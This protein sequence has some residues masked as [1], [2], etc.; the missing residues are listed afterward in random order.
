MFSPE[1][2]I[3]ELRRG[4]LISFGIGMFAGA[5]GLFLLFLLNVFGGIK[6]DL[7]LRIFLVV[8]L[9]VLFSFVHFS[10]FFK[11][12]D[13]KEK[14]DN[15][16]FVQILIDC[17]ALFFAV[18]YGGML[19]WILPIFMIVLL[20]YSYSLL[21]RK[22][23]III[24]I[25]L[26]FGIIFL[27][28]FEYFKILPSYQPFNVGVSQDFKYF[29]TTLLIFSGT[30]IAISVT[31]DFFAGRLQ[32]QNEL[33]KERYQENEELKQSLEIRV[34]AR[35][36]ELRELSKELDKEVKQK[37]EELKKKILELENVGREIVKKELRM[38]ELKKL[39]KN[40]ERRLSEN[41]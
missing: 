16:N 12:A 13:K 9:Y 27:S 19:S 15:F 32:T 37:E 26:L 41:K 31:L 5:M 38:I 36:Q 1:T 30:I 39:I 29:L 7:F 21:P 3:K 10:L 4:A 14:I 28:S 33:L 2:E 34:K 25:F 18:Y 40:L 35:T 17:V 20:A 23:A 11:R 22:R 6:K 24:G 8:F